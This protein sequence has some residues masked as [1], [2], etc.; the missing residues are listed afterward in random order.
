VNATPVVNALKHRV[1]LVA[2][3]EN[4]TERENNKAKL[5]STIEQNQVLNHQVNQMQKIE[6]ISRLTSGIAHDFNNILAAI[7][8]YNQLNKFVAEDCLDEQLKEEIRFNTDQVGKASD[9]AAELI[10]KMMAYSRQ[11]PTNKE[12]EIRPTCEVINEVLD[13]M[14]P[15]LTSIFQLHAEVDGDFTIQI[16]STNLHQILTNLIVNA[17]DAMKQ[18]GNIIISLKQITTHELVCNACIETLEGDFIELS[19]SDTGTGIDQKVIDH[20]F[21]PFFTTKPVGE[22]TGL[23]LSTV[24]GMVH[25]AHGHI[26]IESKTTAPNTGT[27]F[28]LLFPQG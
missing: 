1:G 10:K 11:N 13:M 16:D 27:T 4:I 15:A 22:G 21:D 24:S 6:S 23:G 20:I 5:L 12:I 26:T 17:R 19:I 8:G 3:F 2:E 7:I 18:G 9:R 14:R 25:E 28:R